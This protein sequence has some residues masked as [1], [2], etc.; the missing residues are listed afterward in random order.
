MKI[1]HKLYRQLIP[2]ITL[3]LST[4]AYAY[5]DT[6]TRT[7]QFDLKT[8]GAYDV[9]VLHKYD[10]SDSPREFVAHYT[11][12]TKEKT[13]KREQR[14]V[15]ES[16]EG[17]R[18]TISK[19]DVQSPQKM[20]FVIT[21]VPASLLQKTRVYVVEANSVYPGKL[22]DPSNSI[23]L[24]S[25]NVLRKILE[26][27]VNKIDLGRTKLTLDK[28]VDPTIDIDANLKKID[29]IVTDVNAMAGVGA[30]NKNKLRALRAYLFDAGEW[31]A[32]QPF[33]YNLEKPKDDDVH[34]ALLSTYLTTKKG[35]CVTMPFLF[36]ILAQRL[37]LDVTA[38]NA[39]QHFLVK[40]KMDP[41]GPWYNMETT[42]GGHYLPEE[43]YREQFPTLSD[44][45]IK[46][47]VYLQPLTRKETAAVMGR[48]LIQYYNAQQEYEKAI[49]IADLILE[50]YPKDVEAM[51]NKSGGFA[52]LMIKYRDSGSRLPPQ[53][54]TAEMNYMQ[55]LTVNNRRWWEKAS[56]LG[57]RERSKEE[58][59]QYQQIINE[60]R[61]R[62]TTNLN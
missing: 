46:N 37:G 9:H 18:V 41:K 35:T 19:V 6:D 49:T 34:S 58:W 27:P 25:A 28:M 10:G 38:S 1:S 16:A 57:W 54:A 2:V 11:F 23:E 3:I 22:F 42:S 31:N 55:Y 12:Q 36:V 53:M 7:W 33:T 14:V 52:G 56:E 39:P 32:F 24:K 44:K 62:S 15:F 29:A 5:A 43:G 30:S 59:D 26:Q 20:T 13:D 50:Y 45:A 17:Y 47:G 48:V 61:Q 4:F 40:Y 8:P 51:A 21:D 60:A